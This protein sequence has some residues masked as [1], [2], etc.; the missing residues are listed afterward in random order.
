MPMEVLHISQLIEQLIKEERLKLNELKTRATY[1]DPCHLGR[2]CGVYDPPRNVLTA[3]PGFELIEMELNRHNARCCG[4]GGGLWTYNN[5]L[6][7]NITHS[8]LVDEV[9]PLN[10]EVV[11][12]TCPMCY[13]NFKYTTKLK[14]LPIKVYD[15]TEVVRESLENS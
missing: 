7:R 14:K 10:A 8:L 15:L 6:A 3:I 4:G 5:E 9:L 1:H 2:H 12:T 13:A 11:V